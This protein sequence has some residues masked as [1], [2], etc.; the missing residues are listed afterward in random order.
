[1]ENVDYSEL[2]LPVGRPPEEQM[3][4]RIDLKPYIREQKLIKRWGAFFKF[5]EQVVKMKAKKAGRPKYIEYMEEFYGEVIAK[6]EELPEKRQLEVVRSE[7]PI[8]K[9]YELT[10]LS[11]PNLF[12]DKEENEAFY[13]I[14]I[15]TTL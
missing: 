13:E 4:E 11:K 2:K 14:L 5:W 8:A 3:E 9:L 1:M 6:F 15:D 7:K 12:H 10:N